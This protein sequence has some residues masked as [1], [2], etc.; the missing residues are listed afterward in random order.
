[1]LR[2]RF[3]PIAPTFLPKLHPSAAMKA[4]RKNYDEIAD[5]L[6]YKSK[7]SITYVLNKYR[8]ILN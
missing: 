5:A 4:E 7:S 8:E 1:M 3:I 2:T 6:G